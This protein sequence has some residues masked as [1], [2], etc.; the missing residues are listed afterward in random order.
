MSSARPE[1]AQ[2]HFCVKRHQIFSKAHPFKLM[3][4]MTHYLLVT[5]VPGLK[6]LYSEAWKLKVDPKNLIVF[7]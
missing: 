7:I 6:A 2:G 5:I 1:S 4:A 3:V